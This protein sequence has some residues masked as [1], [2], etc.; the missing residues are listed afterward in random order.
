VLFTAVAA[1]ADIGEQGITAQQVEQVAAVKVVVVLAQ[2][3]I[4]LQQEQQ[5]LAAAVEVLG[6]MALEEVETELTAVL[7]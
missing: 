4:Q 1:V 3:H 2:Q 6:V 7:V 5:T